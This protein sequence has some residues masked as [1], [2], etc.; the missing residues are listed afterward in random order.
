L[1]VG[2]IGAA[3]TR[4]RWLFSAFELRPVAAAHFHCFAAR[5]LVGAAA[6][7]PPT[8]VINSRRLMGFPRPRMMDQ[9]KQVRAVQRSESGSGLSMSG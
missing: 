7:T 9:V 8:S 3:T 1:E 2:C 5:G 6:A 4:S